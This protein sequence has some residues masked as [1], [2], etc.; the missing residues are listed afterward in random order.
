[1]L[2]AHVAG[3]LRTGTMPRYM[4]QRTFNE[5]LGIPAN[6]PAPDAIRQAVTA[7]DLPVDTI[8]GVSVLDPYFYH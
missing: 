1:M 5:G 6:A 4:V 7:N 3:E 2:I 8:T